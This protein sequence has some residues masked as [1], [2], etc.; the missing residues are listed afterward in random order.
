V[1]GGATERKPNAATRIRDRRKEL[2]LCEA[3]LAEELALSVEA[4]G[5]LERYGDELVSCVSLEQATRLAARFGVPLLELV[6]GD[7]ASAAMPSPTQVARRI[8]SHLAAT[9]RSVE[10]LE[11]DAG[12]EVRPLLADPV[13]VSRRQPIMYFQAIAEA[14]Q[15]PSLSLVPTLHMA[16]D[17]PLPG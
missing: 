13:E 11:D 16:H 5:D 7:K 14:M 1:S 15:L 10:S 6:S 4:Y 9:S 3:T 8:A 17:R 2:L 12:W